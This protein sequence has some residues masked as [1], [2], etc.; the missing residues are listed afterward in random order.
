MK[1]FPVFALLGGWS[2]VAAGGA[3][4]DFAITSEVA[5]ARPS[6]LDAFDTT[7]LTG[8]RN[9]SEYLAGENT[10]LERELSEVR[11]LAALLEAESHASTRAGAREVEAL[12]VRLR[13]ANAQR[14]ELVASSASDMS[15]M[16]R[17]LSSVEAKAALAASSAAAQVQDLKREGTI[18]NGTLT[19]NIDRAGA[20]PQARGAPGPRGERCGR[21]PRRGAG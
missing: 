19:P 13:E 15:L 1:F 7:S 17:R 16:K 3:P 14:R 11:E 4:Q 9:A 8:L 6:L 18:R 20:G 10:L 12:R 21:G 5:G 2:A